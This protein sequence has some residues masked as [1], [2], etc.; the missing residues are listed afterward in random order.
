MSLT[1]NQILTRMRSA[2]YDECGENIKNYSET[3]MKF[4]AVASEI[5]AAAANADF[6]LKQAFA[7]TASGK[8]LD[9]HAEMRGLKR[10]TGTKAAGVLTFSV[11]ADLNRDVEIPENT[12]CSDKDNPLVQFKTTESV[13]C[14]AGQSSVSAK[15]EALANGAEFN[16]AANRITV[17][18]NPPDYVSTVTNNGAII[19]GSD[20][21]SDEAIRIRILQSYAGKFNYLTEDAYKQ[22]ALKVD[23][24]LDAAFAY[25]QSKNCMQICIKAAGD[26]LTT[27]IKSQLGGAFWE[28][29]YAGMQYEYI[30]ATPQKFS[31]FAAIKV[32]AG[33][34]KSSVKAAA[35]EKITQL[36]S[37]TKIGQNI[38]STALVLG[39]SAIDGIEYAE[40]S[41]S[42]SAA[43]VAVCDSLGYLSLE[44]VEADV[45]E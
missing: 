38:S 25:D 42:P 32:S 4:K 3:D 11:P 34:D 7:K 21:E 24:V 40:V 10:K 15:C 19:G 2:F 13:V 36:C 26:N 1:Y 44:S 8:Y 23:G 17:M 12:V 5:Y 28:Y 22:L 45:Y 33:A 18:V 35:E 41:L 14:P 20:E 27:G 29:K 37:A 39:L 31:A 30:T 16:C 43:G 9:M 6:V